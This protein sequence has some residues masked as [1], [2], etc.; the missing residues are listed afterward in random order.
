MVLEL[1]RS[2]FERILVKLNNIDENEIS[3]KHVVLLPD[4]FVDHFL[5]ISDFGTDFSRIK[6]TFQQGGGN[7]PGVKQKITQ[8]GN[9]AN[10]ALA[11]ARLG[12]KS[13]LI[14]RTDELGKHLLEYFLGRHGVDISHVKSDGRIAITAAFEFGEK[15]TNVMMGDTG[16][17]SDFRFEDLSQE[18]LNL[19]SK[20]DIVCVTTWN[21]NKNGS[22]LAKKVFEY[23]KQHNTK[24]YLD[25]GDP[26]PKKSEIP[27][28]IETVLRDKN[29]DV[30][31]LNENELK[32]YSNSDADTV[33]EQINAAVS[34]K[35]KMNARIDLHT[36]QFACSITDKCKPI[37][38]PEINIKYRSTGAGDAW[39][40]GNIFA[41][42]LNLEDD[43]RLFFAGSVAGCYIS[44]LNPIH[45]SIN[46]VKEFI[47]KI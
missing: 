27:E 1:D 26:S 37:P 45:P 8:G 29:L 17:V 4:F 28:L 25:T 42:L 5:S 36:A 33:E 46:D 34:L 24:T 43:E 11:L 19:I 9:S 30:L 21:L 12:F 2:L 40:A 41:D 31:C 35:S 47:G 13:H 3:N 20:S 7:V 22:E 18:D 23:A 15:K 38:M 32:Y 44:S 39:N 14:C 16:S 6:E 10:T